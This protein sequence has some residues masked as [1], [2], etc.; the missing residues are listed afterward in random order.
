MKRLG[1]GFVVLVAAIGTGIMFAQ[2]SSNPW[3]G[4][5][6]G[7]IIAVFGLLVFYGRSTMEGSRT[8]LW[9]F[10]VL[11]VVL[12]VAVSTG[13]IT[14]ALLVPTFLGSTVAAIVGFLACIYLLFRGFRM[15]VDMVRRQRTT[16]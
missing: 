1:L 7:V 10:T 16:E 6:T 2:L 11:S 8:R 13:Y 12:L 9:R 14:Y 15:Y 5:L 4:W 3:V